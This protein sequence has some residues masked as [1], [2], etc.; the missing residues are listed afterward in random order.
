MEKK[1]RMA[2]FVPFYDNQNFLKVI[3][4]DYDAK[5]LRYTRAYAV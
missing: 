2:H 5:T 4:D 1:Y 3:F